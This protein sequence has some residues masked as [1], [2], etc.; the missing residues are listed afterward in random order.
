MERLLIFEHSKSHP[1]QR[2]HQ[3]EQCRETE[4]DIRNQQGNQQALAL[5][6]GVCF[7]QTSD[8]RDGVRSQDIQDE[9]IKWVAQ[10][11]RICSTVFV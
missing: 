5:E 10:E 11:S 6:L 1:C 9:G 8:R 3:E 2:F 7:D 4:Q